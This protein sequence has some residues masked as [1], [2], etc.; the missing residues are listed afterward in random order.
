V[1]HFV[2]HYKTEK[3]IIQDKRFCYLLLKMF[4]F[5]IEM[6]LIVTHK[7]ADQRKEA[8]SGIAQEVDNSLSCFWP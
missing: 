1:T 3:K 6:D 2:L 4:N 8:L 7:V 5:C